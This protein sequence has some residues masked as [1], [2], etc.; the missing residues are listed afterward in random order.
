MGVLVA[1]EVLAPDLL[2]ARLAEDERMRAEAWIRST[3]ALAQEVDL[4]GLG[5]LA[6][7]PAL[8]A[9]AMKHAVIA[10]RQA[11]LAGRKAVA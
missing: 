1:D 9:S 8:M 2:A 10:G 7:D 4:S 11:F 5:T 3:F 6:D